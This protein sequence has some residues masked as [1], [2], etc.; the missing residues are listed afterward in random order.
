ML[1]LARHM[2]LRLASISVVGIEFAQGS[3]C[4][5]HN[6]AVAQ[7][8][9]GML[10]KSFRHDCHVVLVGV[11]TTVA[12]ELALTLHHCNCVVFGMLADCVSLKSLLLML[13][14]LCTLQASAQ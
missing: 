12:E 3:S 2:H 6:C 14:L 4:V 8:A 1:A 13:K 5:M 7:R 10:C 11:A 9:R